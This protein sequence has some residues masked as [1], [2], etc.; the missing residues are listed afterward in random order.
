MK[1]RCSRSSRLLI[2]PAPQRT[3]R[4]S[5]WVYWVRL[6][7]I[8]HLDFETLIWF[9]GSCSR[10]NTGNVSCTVTSLGSPQYSTLASR[11]L[12][13]PCSH[14]ALIDTSVLGNNTLSQILS[15]LPSAAPICVIIAISISALFFFA[16]T[17]LSF[18]HKFDEGLSAKLD[19]RIVQGL[20]AWIGLIGFMIG[21]CRNPYCS[22]V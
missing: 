16:Y 6:L 22:S 13:S 4:A 21:A 18:I 11:I 9:A 19:T 12:P 10:A 5:L 14:Y 20:T 15:P 2:S 3:G 17:L 1:S 7:F 8:L